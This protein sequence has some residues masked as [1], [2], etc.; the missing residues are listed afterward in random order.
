VSLFIL[1]NNPQGSG[2]YEEGLDHGDPVN[3]PVKSRA[4]VEAIVYL[5]ADELRDSRGKDMEDE[6]V[7]QEAEEDLVDVVRQC[8]QVQLVGE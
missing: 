1:E 4:L 6:M 2:A 8:V 7:S 5:R 3:V